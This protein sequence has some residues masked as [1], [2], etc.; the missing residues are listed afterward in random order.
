MLQ[1]ANTGATK[2]HGWHHPY[3]RS[4]L[5]SYLSKVVVTNLSF[6]LDGSRNLISTWSVNGEILLV[7]YAYLVLSFA[8]VCTYISPFFSC[9]QHAL[10][11]YPLPNF[12]C[13]SAHVFSFAAEMR[14]L[15][16]IHVCPSTS[17]LFVH[18]LTS[19]SL[20]VVACLKLGANVQLCLWS[21]LDL[22]CTCVFLGS[23]DT[24]LAIIHVCQFTSDVFVYGLTSISSDVVACLK[25]RANVQLCLWSQLDLIYL[26]SEM[27]IPSCFKCHSYSQS[28]NNMFDFSVAIYIEDHVKDESR[29]SRF[30]SL[31]TGWQTHQTE[32]EQSGFGFV[33]VTLSETGRNQILNCAAHFSNRTLQMWNLH[34]LVCD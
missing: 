25:L 9:H 16:Y 19:I 32:S 33:C 3:L 7:Y 22:L 11:I 15:L 5:L 29:H 24:L 27:C 34:S 14:P 4:V 30:M 13:F 8:N 18:G 20:D 12:T 28:C 6:T 21:Y 26:S 17:D 1:K 2:R 31:L 10:Y 23:W